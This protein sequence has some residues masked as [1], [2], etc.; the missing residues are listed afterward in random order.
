MKIIHFVE[1][2]DD[3]QLLL[4]QVRHE[5]RLAYLLYGDR[6]GWS[7]L[8]TAVL[9][10][11]IPVARLII[12]SVPDC[13]RDELLMYH[14]ND[15]RT[16]LMCCQSEQM[17]HILLE[18]LT[19]SNRQQ[20]IKV[21]DLWGLTV[22]NYTAL[23]CL[24]KVLEAVLSYADSSTKHHILT[25]CDYLW[26][27]NLVV[28]AGHGGNR[29]IIQLTVDLLADSDDLEWTVSSSTNCGETIVHQ[30]IA[31]QCVP[32]VAKVLKDIGLDKRKRLL[33]KK[34]FKGYTPHQLARICPSE[35]KD[36]SSKFLTIYNPSAIENLKVN[37]L[38]LTLLHQLCNL[39]QFNNSGCIIQCSMGANLYGTADLQ[40]EQVKSGGCHQ[41]FQ[42]TFHARAD[43]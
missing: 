33:G 17:V 37:P 19:I 41:E 43:M 6:E 25:C 42:V 27:R 23:A 35:I 7:A 1:S 10:D 12:S 3:C 16:I 40:I 32:E 26:G 2:V 28:S 36:N 22:A 13:D 4:D 15:I 31:L 20:L 14:D 9:R 8:H 34:N 30:M 29:E 21:Q 11:N 5:D 39:Y 38:L 24:P 18:P